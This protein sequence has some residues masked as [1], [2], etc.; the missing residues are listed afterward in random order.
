MPVSYSYSCP[1]ADTVYGGRYGPSGNIN[2]ALTPGFV[3]IT[4]YAPTVY[5]AAPAVGALATSFTLT[6]AATATQPFTIGHAFRR[7]D[8][9]AGQGVVVTGAT[10]QVTPKNYW[11]DGSLKFAVISG[12]AALTAA[13]PLQITLTGGTASAGT[14]LTTTDLKATGVTASIA[15]TS[16]GTVSWATTDWDSPFASWVSGHRMTSW[17]Y[18]KAIGADAHLV[19]WLEVRLYAGGEVEVLPWVENG[20][21]NVASPTTK[22]DTFGFTL[23]GS[24]R[25]SQSIAMLPHTRTP[26]VSGTVL[27][28][29]LGTA[30]DV[31][32][33]HNNEYMQATSVVPAYSVD[34][35]AA[36][37]T[38]TA[39][40]TTFTPLQQGAW[41]SDLFGG[42]WHNHVCILPEWDA[43]YLTSSA[44]AT[45][46][47]LIFQGYSAG[48]YDW[49]YRDET[50]NRAPLMAS[51]STAYAPSLPQPGSVSPNAVKFSIDHGPSIGYM[52]YLVTGRWYFMDMTQMAS[53]WNYLVTPAAARQNAAGIMDHR[54]L[55]WRGAAW[56]IRTLGQALSATPDAD[57]AQKAQFQAQLENNID[58]LYDRYVTTSRNPLGFLTVHTPYHTLVSGTVLTGTTSTVLTADSGALESADVGANHF[59]GWTLYIGGQSRTVSASTGTTLTVSSAFSP[60]PTIGAAWECHNP[61]TFSAPWQH[62]YIVAAWGHVKDLAPTLDTT[63][64]TELNA[65]FNQIGKSVVGRMGAAEVGDWNYRDLAPYTLAV[66]PLGYYSLNDTTALSGPWFS[67]WGDCYDATF[68]SNSGTNGAGANSK[69]PYM[70]PGTDVQ[71]P[72]RW[73]DIPGATVHQ[74][75]FANTMRAVAAVVRHGVPGAEQGFQRIVNTSNYHQFV[76]DMEA[77]G[78]ATGALS[79]WALPAWRRGQAVGEWREIPGSSMS[80]HAPNTTLAKDLTGALTAVGSGNGYGS[81]LDAY[82][83]AT[84]DTRRS[85]LWTVAAG[86]HGDYWQNEMVC[87]NLMLDAPTWVVHFAGSNGNVVDYASSNSPPPNSRARYSDGQPAS[88]HTYYQSQFLERHG[89][90]LATGGSISSPGTGY[91][92][93]DGFDVDVASGVNGWSAAYAYPGSQGGVGA[94]NAGGSLSVIAA[95]CCKDPTTEIVYTFSG[96]RVHKLIPSIAGPTAT[97]GSGATYSFSTLSWNSA[98]PYSEGPSAVDTTRSKILWTNG[99]GLGVFTFDIASGTLDAEHTYTGAG[100]AGLTALPASAGAIYIPRLDAYLIRGA[101]SGA[102]VYSVNP[103]TFAVTTLSTTGGSGIPAQS[104]SGAAGATGVYNK[105][106][107]VPHLRGAVY[108]AGAAHNTWFLRLY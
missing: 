34:I 45:Y 78:H 81:R 59:V 83:G 18:R 68:K 48:R 51:Y 31:I 10:A 3:A 30:R 24:S 108:L 89:R 69:N 93:T 27:S 7:G 47:A 75:Q 17:V 49:N 50:T 28:Y 105:W 84:I 80:P 38:I 102:T 15:C 90:A 6:S 100:A 43:L 32:A 53:T 67:T 8:V 98:Y 71:G 4:G 87:Q 11:P 5:Q 62:D 64:Q 12:T 79:P 35:P 107:F 85:T 82:C 61:S 44:A 14:A 26:L 41:D 16:F 58:W 23:G 1:S 95:A 96:S 104:G 86:G 54:S 94:G 52:A 65:V 2:V 29:W 22:T 20:Y 36:S 37:S 42:G 72:I 92:D 88:R 76:R 55:S 25:F 57:T 103:A 73:G 33:K 13:T 39:L 99:Y 70:V 56:G 77:Y 91:Q 106:Q 66:Q 60:A 9:T 19:G 63:M 74:S 40:P 46:K 97:A 21:L 101:A